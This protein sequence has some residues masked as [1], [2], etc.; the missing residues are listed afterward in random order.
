MYLGN[1]P[2]RIPMVAPEHAWLTFETVEAEWAWIHR[3]RED[4]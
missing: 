2:G 3:D 1:R 4:A